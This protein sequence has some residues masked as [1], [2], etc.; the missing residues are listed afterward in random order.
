MRAQ[1]SPP[2]QVALGKPGGMLEEEEEAGGGQ[3]RE[4]LRTQGHKQ[5]SNSGESKRRRVMEQVRRGRQR[6]AR[7]GYQGKP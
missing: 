5:D 4:E 2:A 7:A 1:D 6:E 3:E